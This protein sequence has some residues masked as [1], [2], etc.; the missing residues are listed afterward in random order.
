MPVGVFATKGGDK[1]GRQAGASG[2]AGRVGG[3]NYLLVYWYVHMILRD[4]I[5][6]YHSSRRGRR[7]PAD[8]ST[9]GNDGWSDSTNEII[10]RARRVPV[11]S[12]RENSAVGMPPTAISAARYTGKWPRPPGAVSRTTHSAS[13][14]P[15]A[16]GFFERN[17]LLSLAKI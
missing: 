6:R 1:P 10:A 15:R 17:S 13:A 2:R 7:D 4:T 11:V 9:S 12:Q 16:G 8:P 14:F 5:D 3:R